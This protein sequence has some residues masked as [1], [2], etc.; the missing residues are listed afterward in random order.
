MA[1]TQQIGK[2]YAAAE[3]TLRSS[4]ERCIVVPH[5]ITGCIPLSNKKYQLQKERLDKLDMGSLYSTGMPFRAI[6]SRRN[7]PEA[8]LRL[9]ENMLQQSS[10]GLVTPKSSIFHRFKAIT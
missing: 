1:W 7:N 9:R 10:G 8:I 3:N 4:M 6:Y 2:E 5:V